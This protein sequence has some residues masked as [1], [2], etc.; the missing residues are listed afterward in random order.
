M[1]VKYLT[2]TIRLHFQSLDEKSI[3]PMKKLSSVF[4]LFQTACAKSSGTTHIKLICATPIHE[5]STK[6]KQNVFFQISLIKR[7]YKWNIRLV[8]A[9]SLFFFF[10]CQGFVF[11]FMK[12]FQ[13]LVG[14]LE[15]FEIHLRGEILSQRLE[16]AFLEVEILQVDIFCQGI[17]SCYGYYYPQC[18]CR[19]TIKADCQNTIYMWAQTKPAAF[20]F[21]F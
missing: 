12:L 7:N 18:L 6:Q 1:L 14:T 3:R 4:L 16:S 11:N 9:I 13:F 19:Y 17:W 15:C 2:T 20:F 8:S 5:S 21:F 10:V